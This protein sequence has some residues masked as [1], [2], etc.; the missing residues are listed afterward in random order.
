MMIIKEDTLTGLKKLG[1]TNKEAEALVAVARK[2]QAL[3]AEVSRE[4]GIH[5]P[6]VYRVL[7]SLEAKGWVETS[8]DR[9]KMYRIKDIEAVI[10][11]AVEKRIRDMQAAAETV[12]ADL[13]AL[14]VRDERGR[15]GGTWIIRGWDNT[16]R[17]AKE[18]A[19][20]AFK[21]IYLVGKEPVSEDELK[22]LL[23]ALSASK[24]YINTYLPV[25][26]DPLDLGQQYPEVNFQTPLSSF[27]PDP[28]RFITL[29][30]IFDESQALFINAYYR[31]GR[32]EKGKVYTTW[33]RDPELI[34]ILMEGSNLKLK[35]WRWA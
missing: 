34:E 35:D 33:E 15:K 22:E 21:S 17:K 19:K 28:T 2:G 24:G 11:E 20:N 27:K 5:Y 16:L 14:E 32:L 7:A 8:H 29:F 12:I 23:K 1:L 30:I 10:N 31:E 26:S 4:I 9:P 6:V 25:N 18:L 3:A 13:R